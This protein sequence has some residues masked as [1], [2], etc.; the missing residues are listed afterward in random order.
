MVTPEFGID[1][2]QIPARLRVSIAQFAEISVAASGMLA[3]VGMVLL[4][5]LMMR[6]VRS[7]HP[8]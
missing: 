7:F 2:R 5:A 3:L 1:R 4:L 8:R 6:A